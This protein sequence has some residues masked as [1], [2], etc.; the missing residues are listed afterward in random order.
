MLA[1]IDGKSPVEYLP[2]GRDK[3]RVRRVARALLLAAAADGSPTCDAWE[4]RVGAMNDS[5]F[6][7]DRARDASGIRAAGRPSKP[8]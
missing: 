8:R 1:R 2:A 7:A 3:D 4:R 6:A 5:T